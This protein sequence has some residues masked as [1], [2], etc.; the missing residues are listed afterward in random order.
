MTGTLVVFE[1]GEGAG[2]GTQIR[3]LERHL[4]F[5]AVVTRQPGGTDLGADIRRILLDSEP[6]TVDDRTEAL[7]YAA[8]RAQ[9]VAQV[10]KPA[11]LV[12]RT[13]ISDRWVDS[14]IAYQAAGRRM[15]RVWIEALSTWATAGIVPDLTI[16]LDIDPLDGLQRV[17]HRGS[18]DR[19]ERETL[20]FHRRV[21]QAYLDLADASIG[22]YLVLDATRP[23]DEL[24]DTIARRVDRLLGTV[25]A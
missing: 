19:L 6:G 3:H 25:T 12:G 9:H 15:D 1:G 20:D 2:K 5:Q 23:Q 18:E 17:A 14:S 21:R 22:R 11:L 4:A 24:A 10:V 8:D 13:V 16:L 7:L